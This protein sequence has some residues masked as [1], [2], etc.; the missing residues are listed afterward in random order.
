[1]KDGLLTQDA[2][3]L[4][5]QAAMGKPTLLDGKIRVV[6]ACVK[7]GAS[8]M[9][10]VLTSSAQAA[11]PKDPKAFEDNLDVLLGPC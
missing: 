11:Y 1:M 4:L 6:F 3:S 7:A 8:S 5:Q 10:N 9:A 2:V